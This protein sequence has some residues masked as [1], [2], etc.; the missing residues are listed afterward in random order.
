MKAYVAPALELVV[1]NT[2][3]VLQVSGISTKESGS[4]KE[5]S[6]GENT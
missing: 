6:W 5:F 1:L 2:E 4:F 3:D